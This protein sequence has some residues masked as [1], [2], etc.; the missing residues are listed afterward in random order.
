MKSFPLFLKNDRT[1]YLRYEP[2]DIIF[3]R[4]LLHRE[5]LFKIRNNIKC[6][7]L[8]KRLNGI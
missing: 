4:Y 3:F 5:L 6:E 2:E 8:L 1:S 7:F